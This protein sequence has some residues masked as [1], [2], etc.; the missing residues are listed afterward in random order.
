[1]LIGE[2]M[3]RCR[4]CAEGEDMVDHILLHCCFISG[5]WS[6]F[7]WL[8]VW[9]LFDHNVCLS[10]FSSAS[11]LASLELCAIGGLCVVRLLCGPCGLLE[12]K[13]CSMAK[14]CLGIVVG[15]SFVLCSVDREA[16]NS[17]GGELDVAS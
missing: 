17:I 12:M 11:I 9:S 7:F 4:W 13:C 3:F 10:L 15:L 16:I 5:V 2:E 8:V 1:M 14:N 6:K